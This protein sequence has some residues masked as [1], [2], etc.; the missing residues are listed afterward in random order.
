M[1]LF[2]VNGTITAIG[3][4]LF[5]N[6]LAI[7]AYLEIT[8]AS[9]RRLSV[10]KVAVCNDAASQLQLGSAG[11]FFFD[12]M[13]VHGGRF[14]CQLWGIKSDSMAVFDRR[15]ARK[16]FIVHHILLGTVLLPFAGIGLFWLLPGLASLW[17][18]LS[19]QADRKGLFYGS[20]PAEVQRLQRQQP[21]RI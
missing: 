7:Y 3:Q 11:E 1:G 4:S 20:N 17:T 10:E 13:Y 14:R 12:R 19:G 15:D 21:V 8:E 16:F 5:N 18:V 2:S 6:D 9:G